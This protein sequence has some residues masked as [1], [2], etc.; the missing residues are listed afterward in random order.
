MRKQAGILRTAFVLAAAIVP[1]GAALAD[2]AELKQVADKLEAPR[3]LTADFPL[4]T[5]WL[6]RDLALAGDWVLDGFDDCRL[7]DGPIGKANPKYVTT[8]YECHLREMPGSE[9]GAEMMVSDRAAFETR[10]RSALGWLQPCLENGEAGFERET[11]SQGTT[12][13]FVRIQREGE[14]LGLYER[15]RIALSMES[16]SDARPYN[17][18]RAGFTMSMTPRDMKLVIFSPSWT[19]G[20]P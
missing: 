13:R 2:C 20:A 5:G 15:A 11:G 4:A 19:L 14:T 17:D 12:E 9:D 6:H 8:A 1:A 7:A 3:P 18:P 10:L 16:W